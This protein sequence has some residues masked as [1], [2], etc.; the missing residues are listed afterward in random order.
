[1]DLDE[2]FTLEQ[3]AFFK[4]TQS[5]I[6]KRVVDIMYLWIT[7][8]WLDFHSNAVLMSELSF[9]MEK[10]A[11]VP[12]YD[13]QRLLQVWMD[14]WGQASREQELMNF[15]I[16]YIPL[17]PKKSESDLKSPWILEWDEMDF[18]FQLTLIDVVFF[19]IHLL[20]NSMLISD[21]LDL[22]IILIYCLPLFHEKEELIR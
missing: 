15:A 14:S 12:F 16:S 13:S 10:N 18:A 21:K 11:L 5:R 19:F 6:Q 1:M 4:S 20:Y 7:N 22:R 17:F 2:K 9:F 3:D 8:F